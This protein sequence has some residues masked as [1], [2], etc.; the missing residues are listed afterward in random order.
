MDDGR[1]DLSLR[2][3][4]L[5]GETGDIK[6]P[7]VTNISDLKIGKTVRGFIK[8]KTDVGYFIRYV[9]ILLTVINC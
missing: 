7:E 6:D 5:G 4:H 8:S 1:I 3:S 9:C 2:E